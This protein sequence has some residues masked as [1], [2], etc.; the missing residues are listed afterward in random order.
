[1]MNIKRFE[2][3]SLE[4]GRPV[5]R[6]GIVVSE[7]EG[8]KMVVHIGICCSMRMLRK[9]AY[10]VGILAFIVSSYVIHLNLRTT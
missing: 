4:L 7:N 6:L 10:L 1:M 5:F 2:N 3:G 8:Q 9:I